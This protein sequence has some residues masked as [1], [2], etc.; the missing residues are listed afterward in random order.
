MGGDKDLV[1]QEGILGVCESHWCVCVRVFGGTS[2][3][4]IGGT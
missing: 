4:E 3:T 2:I 1:R